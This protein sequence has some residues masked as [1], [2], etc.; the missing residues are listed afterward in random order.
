MLPHVEYHINQGQYFVKLQ[1]VPFAKKNAKRDDDDSSSTSPT[2]SFRALTFGRIMTEP[3][4]AKEAAGK[5][6]KQPPFAIGPNKRIMI[7][8]E[9]KK[10]KTCNVSVPIRYFAL[11]KA[12]FEWINET[13]LQAQPEASCLRYREE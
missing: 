5:R 2:S 9:T 3:I 1:D 12:I 10:P 7:D 6:R 8:P 11:I 13:L 4:P